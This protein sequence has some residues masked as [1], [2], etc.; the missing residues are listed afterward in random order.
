MDNFFLSLESISSD[1]LRILLH[2]S[3]ALYLISSS[4]LPLRSLP[5]DCY[6]VQVSIIVG[7]TIK[8]IFSTVSFLFSTKT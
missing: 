6:L 5:L 7:V 8:Y 4:P 3:T 2:P 1:V